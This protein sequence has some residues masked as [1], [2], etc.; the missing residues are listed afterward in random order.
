[1]KSIVLIGTIFATLLVTN[2]FP[3]VPPMPGGL[4]AFPFPFEAPSPDPKVNCVKLMKTGGQS[5]AEAAK[6]CSGK[7]DPKPELPK[8]A[9]PNLN[10]KP[11][12]PSPDPKVNCHR[13]MTRMQQTD[14][15]ATKFCT[16]VKPP[17]LPAPPAIPGVPKAG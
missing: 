3:Q 11:E 7:V 1:M 6:M 14:A 8:F 9:P 16:S 4:P 15:A 5:E 17:P 13:L 2:G 12:V 10:L